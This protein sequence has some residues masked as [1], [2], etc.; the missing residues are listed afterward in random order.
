MAESGTRREL[1]DGELSAESVRELLA[2]EPNQ[3]CG[4]VRVSYIS[5]QNAA[6]EQRP[7]QSAHIIGP[8]AIKTSRS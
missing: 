3:T 8:A 2:L 7:S 6:T 5:A 4:F 1:P